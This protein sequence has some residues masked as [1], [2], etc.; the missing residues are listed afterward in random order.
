M[1]KEI[2]QTLQEMR[3]QSELRRMQMLQE[4][5]REALHWNWYVFLLNTESESIAVNQCF[6]QNVVQILNQFN[7]N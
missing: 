7:K 2:E 4:Q 5:V 3:R 1:E 6:H